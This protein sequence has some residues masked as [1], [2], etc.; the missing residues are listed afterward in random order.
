MKGIATHLPKRNAS[1]AKTVIHHIR[2]GREKELYE[3]V[4]HK[5]RIPWST[6]EKQRIHDLR[7]QGVTLAEICPEFPHRRIR[8]IEHAFRHYSNNNPVA[9]VVN[10]CRRW[11]G[12]EERYLAE[13]PSQ[14]VSTQAIAQTLNRSLCS[15]KRKAQKYGAHLCGHN[16]FT[17]EHDRILTQMRTDGCKNPQIAAALGC[18][19]ERVRERWR[20]IRPVEQ[21]DLRLHSNGK[22]QIL[23]AD[24]LA[25]ITR[26]RDE[27]M[28]WAA[29]FGVESY[30]YIA[31]ATLERGYG[32]AMKRMAHAKS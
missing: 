5:D 31:R 28:F 17:P 18:T 10:S 2:Y 19:V 8:G 4:H 9:N 11:T 26:L 20:I 32:R 1:A 13:A 25:S 15:I 3:R 7:E 21:F 24:S 16:L 14:S 30:G 29:V 12:E 6:A 22:G 27:G 23:N